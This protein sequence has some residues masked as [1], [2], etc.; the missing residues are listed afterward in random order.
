MNYSD[1]N[2]TELI[3]LLNILK[4]D[5][6]LSDNER[7]H[8]D[9]KTHFITQI[10]D[11][12]DVIPTRFNYADI[13]EY[14]YRRDILK[15]LSVYAKEIKLEEESIDNIKSLNKD[16]RISIIKKAYKDIY[17]LP[18]IPRE[19]AEVAGLDQGATGFKKDVLY[20]LDEFK[21]AVR[22]S[23]LKEASSRHY[24]NQNNLSEVSPSH[25]KTLK[26]K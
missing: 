21:R 4:P 2:N 13:P 16:A 12:I 5:K 20:V 19:Y 6:S 23:A 26:I 8:L 24:Q 14:G 22:F 17:A 3:E 11:R 18:T 1:F 10:K 15:L 7:L 9:M 25:I